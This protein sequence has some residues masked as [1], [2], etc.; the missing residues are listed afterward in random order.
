MKFIRNLI[1]LLVLSSVTVAIAGD[2]RWFAGKYRPAPASPSQV[3]SEKSC[4]DMKHTAASCDGECCKGQT[5]D[6]KRTQS[7]PADPKKT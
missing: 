2:N 6:P 4:K 5:I 1:T 7:Q 3:N